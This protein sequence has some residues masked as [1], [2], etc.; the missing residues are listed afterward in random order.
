MLSTQ[1]TRTLVLFPLLRR[2]G[3]PPQPLVELAPRY[4]DHPA[5]P[6]G[7][8][9]SPGDELVGEIAAEIFPSP[10]NGTLPLTPEQIALIEL[11]GG[12]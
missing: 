10:T 11:F 3:R 6:H 8:Q 4:P 12:A 9:L 2:R 7:R 1:L 5:E